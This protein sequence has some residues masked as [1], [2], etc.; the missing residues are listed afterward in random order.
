MPWS[1]W[2]FWVVSVSALGA[3][4]IFVRTLLPRRKRKP[5]RTSLT[6]SAGRSA[7]GSRVD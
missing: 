7:D 5:K 6:I 1:D 4:L 3:A 2:Q